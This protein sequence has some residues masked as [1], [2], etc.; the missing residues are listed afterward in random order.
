[1]TGKVGRPRIDP[2]ARRVKVGMTI[3]PVARRLAEQLAG[4]YGL[5]LSGVVELAIRRLAEREGVR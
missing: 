3:S 4:R 1:M 5:S 2:V